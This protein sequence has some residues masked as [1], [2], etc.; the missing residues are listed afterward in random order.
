MGYKLCML[1]IL[2]ALGPL[3]LAG[4]WLIL[5]EPVGAA[6]DLCESAAFAIVALVGCVFGPLWLENLRTRIV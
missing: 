1:L 6:S 3:A 5:V 4:A 2:L